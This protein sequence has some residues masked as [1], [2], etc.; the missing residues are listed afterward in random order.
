MSIG[1][2]VDRADPKGLGRVKVR[3]PGLFEPSG[4]AFPLG[5][6]GGGT[7]DEGTWWIPQLK[8][9]VA[10]WLN[11]GDEDKPYYLPAQWGDGEPPVASDGGDPDVVVMSIGGAYEI[12]VD[13]RPESKGFKIIDKANNEGLLEFDGVTRQLQL[14]AVAGIQLISTGQIDL[15]G[16]IVTING[17]AAG[18][19]KL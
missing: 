8:S 2:V 12:V 17:V 14:S 3:V 13:R 5:Q 1:V 4:W 16:L 11:R 18:L 6:T 15:Q 19:G 7:V 10:I 9:E